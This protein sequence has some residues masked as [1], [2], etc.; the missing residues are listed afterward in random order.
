MILCSQ[1]LKN[2]DGFFG[3][4][5]PFITLSRLDDAGSLAEF[6]TVVYTSAVIPDDPNPRWPRFRVPLNS[7]TDSRNGEQSTVVF[8]VCDPDRCSRDDRFSNS[9]IVG[10]AQ[11]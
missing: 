2:L 9:D 4:S 1:N 3:K 8:K 7:L 11:Q 5:D 10:Q 6:E